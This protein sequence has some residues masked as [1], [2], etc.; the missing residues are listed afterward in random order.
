[1][2]P[3]D[4]RLIAVLAGLAIAAIGVLLQGVVLPA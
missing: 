3:C 4:R 1:M 2:F